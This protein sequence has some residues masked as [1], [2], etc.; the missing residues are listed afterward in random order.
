M[1]DPLGSWAVTG[2]LEFVHAAQAALSHGTT[3]MAPT[4][5]N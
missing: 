2:S 5:S 1:D 4:H 3:F